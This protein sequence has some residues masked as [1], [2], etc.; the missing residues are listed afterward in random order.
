MNRYRWSLFYSLVV[1]LTFVA[2]S[3]SPP[4]QDLQS[5]KPSQTATSETINKSDV[6]AAPVHESRPL[7]DVKPPEVVKPKR[8]EPAKTAA[9]PRPAPLPAPSPAPD[10]VPPAPAAAP[11]PQTAASAP[12]PAYVP[13]TQADPIPVPGPPPP[14]EPTTKNVTIAAGTQ[15]YIRMIDSINAERAH[16]NE[17]FRAS[18]DKDI[19]VDGKTI[20]P[21]RSDVFVK[22]VEVQ[23]A[24]KLKGQSE[25]QVQLDRLFIGKQ[26]YTVASNTFTKTGDSEGKKAAR[27]VGIGAAVG[28]ALGG[29]LGGGKGAVIGAGAGGGGGAVLTK[30]G[31]LQIDSETQL[32]FALDN[33]LD[34]TITEKPAI[35][36][37]GGSDGPARFSVPP[38]DR[39]SS[40][41]SSRTSPPNDDNGDL[42]GNWTVTT[43]GYQSMRLQLSLRQNGNNLNGSITNPY[44]SGTLPIR[45]S[46]SGNY[47]NFS[48]QSQGGYNNI[49]MQ[50]SGAIDHDNMQGSVTMPANN[51]SSGGGYPGGGYPGGG[52]PGGGYPGGGGRRRTGAGSTVQLHWNAQ[53]N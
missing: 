17:T 21:R 3:C 18:L 24:G 10:F 38:P 2:V 40:Q 5:A 27:N 6:D 28:A 35:T 4:G 53:R 25:L 16:Q 20:I 13:A 7:E 52:Y 12:A 15:V 37:S 11:A 47:I 51:A 45:G 43:D 46:V 32:M 36:S 29:I 22:V 8:V 42:T 19:V 49:Q 9:A 34:V 30:P 41:A 33:P 26:S 31:E 23:T 39:S 14:P 48:T 1:L 44:G 50:F